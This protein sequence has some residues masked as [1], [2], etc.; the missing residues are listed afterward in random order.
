[1]TN[2]A[3]NQAE[4]AQELDLATEQQ[5]VDYL[6]ENPGFFMQHSPLLN[7][8]EIPHESGEAISLV[9]RQVSILRERNRHFEEKLREM[10]DAVHD[11][12]RLHVSL[13]RLA[14]N[15]FDTDSLDDILGVVD[16][17]LR[18]KLGT[19]FVY[20]RLYSEDIAIGGE[21]E[22]HTYVEQ[23]DKVLQSFS[24]LINKSRIQCGH[25]TEEQINQ[26]FLDDAAEV[27]SAAIIPVS[28]S[29]V[30]GI[31][32]LG[33]R[34]KHRYHAGMG[35]DFLSS[36]ADLIGASMRSLLLK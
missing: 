15:L 14:I 2:Q 29:G 35:T 25:F 34:D 5:V 22:G 13:N 36:L 9:E 1:V 8:L 19:D 31:I 4:K 30:H 10:V 18:H 11:N 27:A 17:E 28:D 24:I 33:S 12:Q 6:M 20:F 16:D 26:L 21:S 23:D 7:E 32:A 3:N